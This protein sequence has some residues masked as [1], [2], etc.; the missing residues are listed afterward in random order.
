[1]KTKD[2]YID[3]LAAELKEWSAQIDQ[4]NSKMENAVSHAKI[5]YNEELDALR[6][7]Q[8]AAA[9][10]LKELQESSGDSWESL[11]ETADKIWEDLKTGVTDA[12]SKF[13]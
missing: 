1:M 8:H 12:A 9:E 10:K 5:K 3:S 2:E 6:A 7:N 4:L 13:K 11:K